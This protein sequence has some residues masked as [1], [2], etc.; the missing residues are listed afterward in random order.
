MTTLDR[1][2]HQRVVPLRRPAPVATVQGTLAL[3]LGLGAEELPEPPPLTIVPEESSRHRRFEAWA[4]RYTQ[5]AV[6]IAG[7]DRP[8]SQ[9]LRWTAPRVYQD[10]AR[11]AQL[12][13]S[14]ALREP[15]T[16]RVQHVR[17]HVETVHATWL[18]EDVAEV[19]ARV[20]Y[21]RRCRAV[22]LRFE[23]RGDRWQ[24]TALEFA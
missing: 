4:H 5:A 21:G 23:K 11:R 20:R 15:G 17:P 12:V 8:V 3:D 10:L 1:L 9:L 19:C 18:E 16:A 6:E 22:A 13:R 7:G 14:A 2:Y 24:A